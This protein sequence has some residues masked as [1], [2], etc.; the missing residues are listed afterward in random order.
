VDAVGIFA[1]LFILAFA[2]VYVI[3]AGLAGMNTMF[4]AI[5]FIGLPMLFL[6]VSSVIVYR[7]RPWRL[8]E[9]MF[10]LV[11]GTMPGGMMIKY[12]SDRG[13]RLESELNI[14]IYIAVVAIASFAIILAGAINGLW[15]VDMLRVQ[16]TGVRLLLIVMGILTPPAVLIGAFSA[17]AA[18]AH[19]THNSEAAMLYLLAFLP[20]ASVICL[21]AWVRHK[22]GLPMFQG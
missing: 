5:L 22:L 16:S 3:A 15:Y 17:S 4:L 21:R 19:R 10:V 6:V 14:A 11:L 18:I 7:R 12:F 13:S 2:L 9:F 8:M 1:L 20:C